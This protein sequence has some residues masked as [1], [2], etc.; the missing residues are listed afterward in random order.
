MPLK[1]NV[2]YHDYELSDESVKAILEETEK[3]AEDGLEHGFAFCIRPN[4][5]LDPGR[6]CTGTECEIKTEPECPKAGPLE[7][8]GDFHTHP[9]ASVDPSLGDIVAALFRTYR[10]NPPV[11]QFTS[12]GNSSP[13]CRTGAIAGGKQGL[14]CD[15]WQVRPSGDQEHDL[16]TRRMTGSPPKWLYDCEYVGRSRILTTEALAYSYLIDMREQGNEEEVRWVENW[17]RRH[18]SSSS[19][20]CEGEECRR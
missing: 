6:R 14:E 7:P 18:G 16:E 15:A 12:Y 4:G 5:Q 13:T 19:Q 17:L 3:S 11:L 8:L 9:R 20:P 2:G 1:V 10:E